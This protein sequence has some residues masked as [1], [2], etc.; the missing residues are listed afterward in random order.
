MQHK[1]TLI[2]TLFSIALLGGCATDQHTR[3][4]CTVAGVVIGGAV[5]A[6]AG[7]G[8]DEAGIAAGS[9]AGGGL[10]GW[11]ACGGP[12]QTAPEPVGDSDGDGV[13]DDNDACPGTPRGA[14]VDARGCPMDSDG[15]RVSDGLDRCP[16]TPSGVAVDSN[17]CPLDTDGDGV[18]DNLDQCPGTPRGV[19]AD[20]RGCPQVGERILR[21]EGITFATDSSEV[22]AESRTVLDE[23]VQSLRNNA[24]VRVRVEGH[25]DSR[26]TDA[27][28]QR[29]SERRAQAVVD[30]LVSQG[31]QRDRVD[32]VGFGESM[33]VAPNDTEENMAR[34]RR[35]D[36][37]VT[38]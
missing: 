1:P 22:S 24:V 13:N 36:F 2:M 33:P 26:G 5:G 18:T 11:L 29:L 9:A 16:N 15:D 3:M 4:L 35:V 34:N 31:I 14:T 32:P 21:L 37:V 10:A 12:Q 8:D 30:Y 19:A 28:N 20:S 23:A 17:G 38:E 25:A 6:V 7:D 27:Y